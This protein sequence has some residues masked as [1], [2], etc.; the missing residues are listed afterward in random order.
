MHIFELLAPTISRSK[1]SWGKLRWWT[2]FQTVYP[3]ENWYIWWCYIWKEVPFT[4]YMFGI[5]LF[6][7]HGVPLIV[8][9]V[10]IKTITNLYF[11]PNV[12]PSQVRTNVVVQ[13]IDESMAASTPPPRKLTNFWAPK[14]WFPWKRCGPFKD[15]PCLCHFWYPC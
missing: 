2:A 3:P 7:F 6:N 14:W 15:W 12:C 11:F 10:Q 4:K 1:R 8:Q 13:R 5:H 9:G